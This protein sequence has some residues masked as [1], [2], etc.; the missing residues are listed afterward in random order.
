M[1]K[2]KDIDPGHRMAAFSAAEQARKD[3]MRALLRTPEVWRRQAAMA[4]IGALKLLCVALLL[5]MAGKQLGFDNVQAVAVGA[6]I[7]FAMVPLW[8]ALFCKNLFREIADQAFDA[9]LASQIETLRKRVEA[10]TEQARAFA[11]ES[12]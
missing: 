2:S 8:P 12:R 1:K 4:A 3:T 6:C 9:E 11:R 5:A 10:A 7:A